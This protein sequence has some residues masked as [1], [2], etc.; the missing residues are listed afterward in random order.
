MFSSIIYFARAGNYRKMD[1]NHLRLACDAINMGSTKA[2]EKNWTTVGAAEY[3]RTKLLDPHFHFGQ[4][5]GWTHGSLSPDM[6][7]LVNTVILSFLKEHSTT[8]QNELRSH[9][10]MVFQVNVFLF[11]FFDTNLLSSFHQV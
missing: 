6:L 3:W 11:F 4:H 5:G 9:I 10:N 1:T 8:N 2:A 7:P